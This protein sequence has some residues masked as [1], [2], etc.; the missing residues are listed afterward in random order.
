MYFSVKLQY[1]TVY[2]DYIEGNNI[3]GMYIICILYKFILVFEEVM[4]YIVSENVVFIFF[5]VHIYDYITYFISRILDRRCN[6]CNKQVAKRY[7][8]KEKS[9]YTYINYSH[10]RICSDL[11]FNLEFINV[12]IFL[13]GV[14]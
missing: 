11:F 8:R 14:I 5:Y 10:R 6:L 9:I 4:R 2:I 3:C 13:G 7:V 1:L 12:E